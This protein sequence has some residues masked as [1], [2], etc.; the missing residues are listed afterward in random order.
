MG[1]NMCGTSFSKGPWTDHYH[2]APAGEPISAESSSPSSYGSPKMAYQKSS[3]RRLLNLSGSNLAQRFAHDQLKFKFNIMTMSAAKL[4][5]HAACFGHANTEH[6]RG[7]LLL[8][9]AKIASN[10][11]G[12]FAADFFIDLIFILI[13]SIIRHIFVGGGAPFQWKNV[14]GRIIAAL[15]SALGGTVGAI[16]GA[17]IGLVI[18]GICPPAGPYIAILGPIIGR[19][20]GGWLYSLPKKVMHINTSGKTHIVN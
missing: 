11:V 3:W 8:H 14:A 5:C 6:M 2:Y 15:R 20:I 12:E 4:L 17:G 10:L 7:V 19:I 13:V 1:A 9:G 18:T 16:V